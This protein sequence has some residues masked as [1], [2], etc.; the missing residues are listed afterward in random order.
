MNNR[1][2]ISQGLESNRV[3]V[4]VAIA[5]NIAPTKLDK[6][7]NGIG[8]SSRCPRQSLAHVNTCLRVLRM[9]QAS[10]GDEG[11]LTFAYA[12]RSN[13]TLSSLDLRCS[14]ISDKGAAMILKALQED[15]C[16]LSSLNYQDNSPI[17]LGPQ[18]T[19]DSYWPHAWC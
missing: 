18:N 8:L 15:N 9:G 16:V 4:A 14:G 10:I 13:S 5:E 11:A 12:L 1:T 3:G 6:S 7:D 17:S 19:V 2:L